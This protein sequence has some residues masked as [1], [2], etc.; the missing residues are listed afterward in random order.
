MNVKSGEVL[1]NALNTKD[2][3]KLTDI[4]DAIKLYDESQKYL[5]GDTKYWNSWM[6]S[7]AGGSLEIMSQ[8]DKQNRYLPSEF[9]TTPTPTMSDKQSTLDAKEQEVFTKIITNQA[10]VDDFDKFVVD[11]KSLGGDAITKEV[12][13]WYSKKDKK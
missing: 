9:Y 2:T 13:E 8:Y 6:K 3:S 5:N 4:Q 11:W 12:N 1:P 7:R 10:S